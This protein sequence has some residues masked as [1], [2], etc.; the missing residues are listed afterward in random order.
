MTEGY[1]KEMLSYSLSFVG[2]YILGIL[3]FGVSEILYGMP[4]RQAA[5]AE[6]YEEVKQIYNKRNEYIEAE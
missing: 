3:T 4:Y 5:D 2:Q 6:M 1:K